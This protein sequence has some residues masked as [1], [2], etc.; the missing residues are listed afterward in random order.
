[1]LDYNALLTAVKVAEC[2]SFTRAGEML[3]TP[4]ST[5][6]ARVRALERALGI[7]LFER[8][9]RRVRVTEAGR[10]FFEHAY[11]GS[12]AFQ[13]AVT[14]ATG[15]AGRPRGVLR[16]VAP[17][18]FA[19]HLLPGLLPRF[20]AKY[21]DLA[22]AVDTVNALPDLVA[23]GA[24]I[25]IGVG[26]VQPVAYTRRSLFSFSQAVYASPRLAARLGRPVKPED[27]VRWPLLSLQSAPTPS[28]VL[29]SGSRRLELA[30]QPKASIS[31]VSAIHDL[32]L[33]GVGAALLPERLCERDVAAGTLVRLLPGWSTPAAEVAAYFS[34]RRLLP[35]KVKVFLEYLVEWFARPPSA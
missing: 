16:V 32:A 5:V 13:D 12:E 7:K 23:H 30:L 20:L 27:L 34:G 28:W 22:V 35:G 17:S 6:S 8:S 19:R 9:T 33:A 26:S 31:D 3:Q 15:L 24:D 29:V 2:S 10:A 1:V 4:A 11:R 18:L 25:G 14:A 21:P